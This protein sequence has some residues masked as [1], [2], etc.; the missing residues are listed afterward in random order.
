MKIKALIMLLCGAVVLHSC[1]RYSGYDA[2]D[3][4]S[5]DTALVQADSTEFSQAKLVKTAEMSFEVKNVVQTS[6]QLSALTAQYGGMVMHH[7]MRS[8]SQNMHDVQ[9][10][11]DSVMRV[12]AFSTEADMT[13]KVPSQKLDEF[14]NKAGRMSTH[15]LARNM[16]IEDRSLIYLESQLRLD[17]R[18]EL[19]GQQK[20]GRIKLQSPEDVLVFKDGLVDEQ[21]NKRRID[22]A[23]KYSTVGLKFSQ[24]NT[25][26]KEVIAND[27][28]SVYRAPFLN[29]LGLAML[30]GVQLFTDVVVGLAHLWLFIISGI[31][32]FIAAK[33]Y[34]NMQRIKI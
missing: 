4:E 15:V 1:K 17:S 13:V 33:K 9:I 18:K 32:I 12:S 30:S 2:M 7:H 28:P 34:I 27:D 11:R 29:R 10:S 26:S 24:H 22:K 23:V 5:S 14:M 6:E 31:I 3:N 20:K 19:L 21:I 8:Y 16:D 25:I